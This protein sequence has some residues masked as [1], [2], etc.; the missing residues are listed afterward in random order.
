MA[1]KK[2]RGSKQTSNKSNG[3]KRTVSSHNSLEILAKTA[4]RE[5]VKVIRQDESLTGQLREGLDYDPIHQKRRIRASV[6]TMEEVKKRVQH[7]CPD[8]PGIY[9]TEEEWIE[10]NAFPSPAYD[11]EERFT[12]SALACAIW[13]LDQIRDINRMKDLEAV[14]PIADSVVEIKYPPIWDPCHGNEVIYNV[15]SAILHRNDPDGGS[16]ENL[17]DKQRIQRYY[18]TDALAEGR[19][20]QEWNNRKTFNSILSLIPV[21]AIEAAEQLYQKKYWDF[22]TRY[23]LSR[24]VFCEID[25]KLKAEIDEF[26]RRSSEFLSG[27]QDKQA[28]A[29]RSMAAPKVHPLQLWNPAKKDYH[30]ESGATDYQQMFLQ[31]QRIDSERVDLECREAALTDLLDAF[32]KEMWALTSK[33]YTYIENKYGK[34]IADIWADCDAGDPYT[35]CFAFM[36]LLDKGSDLPWCYCAGVNLHACYA[37]SLPWPRMKFN[38]YNDGIWYHQEPDKEGFSYGPDYQPLPK[39]VRVPEFDDWMKL[40]F[41]DK[42]SEDSDDFE[43]FNLSHIMYELTGCIMPRKMDRYTP[44]LK[45]LDRYGI[46]GKKT[47]PLLYCASALGEARH[48]TSLSLLDRLLESLQTD[49]EETAPTEEN[50]ESLKAQNKALQEEVRRLKEAAYETGREVQ[51][52]NVRYESIAQKAAN[53]AQEL[54]DLRE[55]IFNQQNAVY[56]EPDTKT[57]IVF[58]YRTTRKIVVFGGHDSWAR[59]M[60][61]KFP[62]IRFID[63]DMMPN[64]DL[65]R[66]ADTIWIQTNALAHKHFYIIID[67]VRKYGIPLRYFTYSGVVKCAEQIVNDDMNHI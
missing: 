8:V 13:M 11:Y 26:E 5:R 42:M 61:P 34:E 50:E 18:M 51:E 67:E 40:Q 55:L 14:L 7:L 24:K 30:V 19:V 52:A 33:P 21:E 2:R 63:R 60:K 23:F 35:M 28:N 25:V 1:N 17:S 53:D 56:D 36:S 37:A 6:S 15:V 27:F 48:R 32:G 9:S 54:H 58:P 39:K 29:I 62:D 38:P 65:I 46:R 57:D 43:K 44:A 16:K 20:S 3:V 10:I 47:L 41:E 59:E 45:I 4:Y 31:V 12:F 49:S 66:H 64:P 22:V